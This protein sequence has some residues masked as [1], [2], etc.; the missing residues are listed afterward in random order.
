MYSN[1]KVFS[2]GDKA[3]QLS[4]LK[5]HVF[6]CRKLSI[7]IVVLC[8]FPMNTCLF[9]Y[10]PQRS[11]DTSVNLQFPSILQLTKSFFQLPPDVP[12]SQTKMT[13]KYFLK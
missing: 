13:I 10:L 12:S 3:I 2:V 11:K 9:Y 1:C 4:N 6:R 7:F 5:P 8:N